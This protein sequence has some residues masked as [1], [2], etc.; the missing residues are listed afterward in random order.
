VQM[1]GAKFTL[2]GSAHDS[3][4]SPGCIVSGGSIERSVLSPNVRVREDA[5]VTE[6][7]IL[8]NSQIGHKAVVHRAILDKNVVVSDNAQVGVNA[9]DDR[10]RG[11]DVSDG[12]IT[13]IGK[14][15]TVTA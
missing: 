12:G 5:E 14:G 8:A 7:V 1:P 11:F 6:S 13:V 4:V 2:R 9:E 10:A 15:V 3:I